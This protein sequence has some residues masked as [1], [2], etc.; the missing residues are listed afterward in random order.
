M[1][2]GRLLL[3]AAL[4]ILCSA[5]FVYAGAQSDSGAAASDGYRLNTRGTFPL[6]IGEG[7]R[8]SM[9]THGVMERD[10]S[11]NYFIEWYTDLTKVALDLTIVTTD[12]YK[13]KLNLLFA[14]GDAPDILAPSNNSLTYWTPG[15]Q[16]QAL[17]QERSMPIEGLIKEHSTYFIKFLDNPEFEGLR[18]AIT[19]PDGH[20]TG[21]PDIGSCYHCFYSQKMNVNKK[22]LDNL[23]LDYPETPQEFKEMLIAFRDRDANGNGN[24]NDEIPLAFSKDGAMVQIDGFLMNAFQYTAAYFDRLAVDSTGKVYASYTTD[25]YR[26]GLKYLRELW[27]EDLIYKES[28]VQ[29]RTT[30]V[31]LNAMNV[32]DEYQKLGAVPAMH[33]GYY[34]TGDAAVE[35]WREWIAIP[36]LMDASGNRVACNYESAYRYNPAYKAM[37]NAEAKDPGLAFRYIDMQWDGWYDDGDQYEVNKIAAMGIKGVNWFDPDPGGVG[38]DGLPATQKL[39]RDPMP[40]DHPYYNNAG[41]GVLA[42]PLKHAGWQVPAGSTYMDD[43]PSAYEQYL[44]WVTDVNYAPYAQDPKLVLPRLFLTI[45]QAIQVGQ[46]EAKI[47]SAVETG[48]A[49][50]VTGQKD[51]N[52]NSD[53]QTFLRDLD[54]LG[55]QTYLKIYQDAY[56]LKYKK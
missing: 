29:D 44:W 55:L 43:H 23:G 25:G 33:R 28:F 22:W 21:I 46:F 26:A 7:A 11:K 48:I 38:Y 41:I 56:D 42:G 6:V 19:T 18:D 10:Y 2:K 45:E 1:K 9:Y 16:M 14:S 12:Q 35:H 34:I 37:I 30:L 47:K 32:G 20:I 24:P 27:D 17:A 49:A 40:E 5:A 3:T 13:E 31:R 4:L 8:V 53:W 52:N 50:F 36:P 15:E 51:I 54:R 39:N